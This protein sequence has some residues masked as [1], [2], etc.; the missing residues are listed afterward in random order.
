MKTTNPHIMKLVRDL[1]K[2][3]NEASEATKRAE[4]LRAEL[5]EYMGSKRL[6]EASGHAVLIET[7]VRTALDKDALVKKLGIGVLK[8]FYIESEYEVMTVKPLQ[9]NKRGTNAGLLL[10]VGGR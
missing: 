9:E 1:V 4:E 6:L 2:A 3:R 10:K 8:R 5:K 7:R